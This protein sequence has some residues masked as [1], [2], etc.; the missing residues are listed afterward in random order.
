ML[1]VAHPA[2][3]DSRIGVAEHLQGGGLG[4][5][6]GTQ[7]GDEVLVCSYFI[8][9]NS[10]RWLLLYVTLKIFVTLNGSALGGPLDGP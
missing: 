2:V 6:Q 4:D 3:D 9:G 7:A 5:T 8:R 1:H 10:R